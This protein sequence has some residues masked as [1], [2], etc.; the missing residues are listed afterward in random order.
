MAFGDSEGL[1]DDNSNP[2]TRKSV[3]KWIKL[4][5]PLLVLVIVGLVVG[6][7][8]GTRKSTNRSS[9]GAA[10]AGSSGN[11]TSASSAVSAKLAIGRFATATDSEF[12]VPLY[13][14][15]VRFQTLFLFLLP[16]EYISDKHCCFYEPYIH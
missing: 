8:V 4:G 10:S 7:V 6:V 11:A 15:T 2:R 5:I 16:D 12:M 13:P 3:R 14:S 9:S 1:L